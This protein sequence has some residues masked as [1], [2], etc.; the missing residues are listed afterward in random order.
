MVKVLEL[1]LSCGHRWWAFQ[2]CS[3]LEIIS[4]IVLFKKVP[5]TVME[6]K[7]GGVGWLFVGGGGGG[8]GLM[9]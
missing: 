1:L 2:C 4:F 8:G 9:L 5:V 7:L 3:S 6:I